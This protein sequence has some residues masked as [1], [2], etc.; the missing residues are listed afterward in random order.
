MRERLQ[1]PFLYGEWISPLVQLSAR[2]VFVEMFC[3]PKSSMDNPSLRVSGHVN[4]M[5]STSIEED[6]A[7]D[8][9]GQWAKDEMTGEQGYVDDERSCF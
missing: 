2:T 6:C 1:V 9:F 3:T 5:N 4:S 7:E 8:E